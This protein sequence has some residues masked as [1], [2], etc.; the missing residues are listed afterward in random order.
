MKC[1]HCK[2]EVSAWKKTCPKCGKETGSQVVLYREKTWNVIKKVARFIKKAFLYLLDRAIFYAKKSWPH[3]KKFFSVKKNVYIT[4]GALA[5]L[6]LIFVIL[7]LLRGPSVEPPILD[8]GD[9]V[10]ELEQSVPFTGAVL[11]VDELT[12]PIYGFEMVVPFGAYDELT[13]FDITTQTIESHN[14]GDAFTPITPL[15]NI[16]NGH[17]FSNEPLTLTIPIELEEGEFAMGFYFNPETNSLEGIPMKNLTTTEITLFTY[18]FSSIVISK[19]SIDDLL[20]L[21]NVTNPY[22]DTGFVP[23]VDDWQFT[24]YGSFLAQGG[25]CAGQVLT[26]SW[27]YHTQKMAN[28]E[29]AL[30]NRFDNV[31]FEATESFMED[32]HLGYRFASVIQNLLD[33][34][35]EDF[36]DY[37][38]F[39]GDDEQLIYFAFSYAMVITEK[40]QLMAIY[41]H[42]EFGDIVSG[43]AIMAYKMQGYD[44]YVADPNYPGQTNRKVHFDTSL[45]VYEFEPYSSG[46]NAQAILD[47]GAL[48]YDDIFYIGESA[49]IDYEA[50]GEEYNKVLDGTIGDEYFPTLEAIFLSEYDQN[51][52]DQV[53]MDVTGDEITLGTTHNDV[54]ACYLQNKVVIAVT[55]NHLDAVYTLYQGDQLIEG[56]YYASEDGYIYYEVELVNG[57]NEIG[58]LAE[59]VVDGDRYYADFMRIKINYTA[60]VTTECAATIVGRYNFYS[61]SDGQNLVQNH[62]IIIREDG[63]FTESYTINDPLYTSVIDGTWTIAPGQNAGENILY[64]TF[65][66]QTDTYE[67]LDNYQ[68]LRYAPSDV[69]F[70]FQKES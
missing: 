33:F 24:N 49:L 51:V 28:D 32:D 65:G 41:S 43:H 67:V 57:E 27:Y 54:M 62:Y 70:L 20:T 2:E 56:P 45:G 52:D 63:T 55:A 17:T 14:L 39:A 37:L 53:W 58:V 15:I 35:S 8:L 13:P 7:G 11:S 48:L 12:S 44:I 66:S 40:P 21:T 47:D 22:V 4:A 5:G 31:G 34:T 1:A 38:S 18:H 29:P 6:I 46:A 30:Y 26:M 60:G 3:I 19:I 9:P 69:I 23:G 68:W 50:I 10:A 36:Y 42:D 59:I 61:R 64:L 25:H 16:D